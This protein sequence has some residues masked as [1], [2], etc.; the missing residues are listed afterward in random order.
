MDWGTNI[1]DSASSYF[2]NQFVNLEALDIGFCEEVTTIALIFRASVNVVHICH[3]MGVPTILVG[4][5]LDLR[6]DKRFFIDHPGAHCYA[7]GRRA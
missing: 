4:T 2:L 1:S 7:S 3:F 6:D 5:K